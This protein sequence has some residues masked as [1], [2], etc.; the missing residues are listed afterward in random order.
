MKGIILAGGPHPPVPAHTRDLQAA[1]A[2]LRQAH[3]LLPAVHPH[4]G[5]HP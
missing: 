2:G 5:G 3:D 1:A 4:A